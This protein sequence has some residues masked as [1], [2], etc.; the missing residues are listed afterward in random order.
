M[1]WG[2]VL[3]VDGWEMARTYEYIHRYLSAWNGPCP[4]PKWQLLSTPKTPLKILLLPASPG[5]FTT[6]AGRMCSG[7]TSP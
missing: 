1:R 3:H 2:S 7:D 6:V 4:N 5:S